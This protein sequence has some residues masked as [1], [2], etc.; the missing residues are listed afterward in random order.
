MNTVETKQ[1]RG[2]LPIISAVTFTGFLDTTLLIPIIALYAEELGAGVGITGLIIGLYSIANTPANM[3]F[4]RLI[5]KV[6][7]SS[8]TPW[9]WSFIRCVACP[10]TWGW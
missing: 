3:L 5:D 9:Q 6:G 1:P 8:V 4:G 7:H 10:C 2:T